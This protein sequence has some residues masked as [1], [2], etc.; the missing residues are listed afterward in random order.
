MAR[1]KSGTAPAPI[2]AKLE[3]SLRHTA[4]VI[5]SARK[6]SNDAAALMDDEIVRAYAEGVS[7]KQLADILGVQ[8]ATVYTALRRMGVS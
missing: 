8:R 6:A 3:K 5:A 4:Q 1:R 7:I 2:P